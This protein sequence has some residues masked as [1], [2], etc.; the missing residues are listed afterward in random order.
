VGVRV[1]VCVRSVAGTAC[2]ACSA[3]YTPQTTLRSCLRRLI[4]TGWSASI[5]AAA[6]CPPTAGWPRPP[7]VNT[8]DVV[9]VVVI[10]AATS[11]SR[12]TSARRPRHVTCYWRH[13]ARARRQVRRHRSLTTRP[14]TTGWRPGFIITTTQPRA[15]RPRS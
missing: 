8:I 4:R 13:V 1:C 10:V 2:D 5:D 7:P 9:I 12:P 3:N 15:E 14:G 11:S 6:V